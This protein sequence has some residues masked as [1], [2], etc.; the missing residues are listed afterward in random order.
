M[1][2]LP[3]SLK[4]LP[5]LRLKP[6]LL[7]PPA[8][9]RAS[10]PTAL[11]YTSIAGTSPLRS[12]ATV[13]DAPEDAMEDVQARVP[14]AAPG[15]GPVLQPVHPPID[16]PPNRFGV[17]RRYTI[18]PRSDPEE[19]LTLDAF[20]DAS[21]HLRVPLDPRERD[22]SDRLAVLLVPGSHKREMSLPTPS[23]RSS[24]GRLSS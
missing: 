5:H 14:P 4:G 8:G 24:T 19:G 21:I 12:R 18:T 20:A 23:P 3:T 11:S 6:G 16:T 1:D 17:L 22:P 7:H 10:A 15:P 9:R 13:G 2:M